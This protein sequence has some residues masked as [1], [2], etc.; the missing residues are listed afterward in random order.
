VQR[1]LQELRGVLFGSGDLFFVNLPTGLHAALERLD[2]FWLGNNAQFPCGATASIADLPIFTDLFVIKIVLKQKL[3]RYHNIAAWH[4]RLMSV[5]NK[6]VLPFVEACH[7]IA[8]LLEAPALEADPTHVSLVDP[9]VAAK[10]NPPASKQPAAAADDDDDDDDDGD[11][12]DDDAPARRSKGPSKY[13]ISQIKRM[14]GEVLTQE[15]MWARENAM[16]DAQRRARY[17]HAKGIKT[18][19]DLIDWQTAAPQLLAALPPSSVRASFDA[20]PQLN[21]KVGLYHGDITKLEIDAIVNAANR[22]LL[23][24]GGIDGAIHRAAGDKLYCECALLD[25]ANTGECKVTRGYDLPAKFVLHCVGPIGEHP[26]K[27]KACYV[28]A[29]EAA[30]NSNGD[31][32]V[33]AF[34]GISTGIYGYPLTAA[35]HVALRSCREWLEVPDNAAVV[36]LLLFVT[37]LDNERSCYVELMQKYFPLAAATSAESDEN[38]DTATEAEKE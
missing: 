1:F 27:L 31:I 15:Q 25:G 4:A 24:G 23:G 8:E 21:A 33:V 18:R 14:Y 17:A 35:A 3:D 20:S 37:F 5:A 9:P 11:D 16:T 26:E 30:K 10:A 36:D 6:H 22:S 38:T 12:D 13:A 19:A 2:R 7:E 28:N 29:L 34:C 32:R